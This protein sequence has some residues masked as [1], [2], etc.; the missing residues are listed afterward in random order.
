MSGFQ[1][2]LWHQQKPLRISE[3]EV[4]WQWPAR[5]LFWVLWVMLAC[6]HTTY[7]LMWKTLEMEVGIFAWSMNGPLSK[8][9][10]LLCS[11]T[12]PYPL[13]HKES[14]QLFTC[15]PLWYFWT[16]NPSCRGFLS[17]CGQRGKESSPTGQ[18]SWLSLSKELEKG[19]FCCDTEPGY[20][21]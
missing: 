5:P 17:S 1:L 16:E 14:S 9:E 12:H 19:L 3:T 8:W 6:I 11:D 21:S 10:L 7:T 20:V 4:T 13:G 18:T 15:S 2:W